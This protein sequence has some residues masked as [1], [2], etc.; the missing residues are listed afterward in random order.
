MNADDIATL[1]INGANIGTVYNDHSGTAQTLVVPQVH[2][3]GQQ[4]NSHICA[5]TPTRFVVHWRFR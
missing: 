5:K 4:F 2:L 3:T 1:Y